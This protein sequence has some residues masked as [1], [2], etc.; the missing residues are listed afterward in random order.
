[1]LT[2][3]RAAAWCTAARPLESRISR[4]FGSAKNNLAKSS[5][6][7]LSAA[8]KEYTI[9]RIVPRTWMTGFR[10]RW[11]PRSIRPVTIS[12][13]TENPKELFS[14]SWWRQWEASPL[15][16][17]CPYAGKRTGWDFGNSLSEVSF[18]TTRW[19]SLEES[20]ANSGI[21]RWSI[22]FWTLRFAQTFY[23][24]VFIC[25]TFS[26]LH[27]VQHTRMFA[28]EGFDWNWKGESHRVE[29]HL[30]QSCTLEP[31]ITFPDYSA[32]FKFLH[33]SE[34]FVE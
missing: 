20:L 32:K 25:H 8:W 30:C 27:D 28:S 22:I 31:N 24:S 2:L 15:V 16:W 6:F 14:S 3:L 17:P 10:Y 18:S 7:P 26:V 29:F 19:V 21:C 4:R 9:K 33:K 1:M 34:Y 5:R 23:R 12:A 13:R 11:V